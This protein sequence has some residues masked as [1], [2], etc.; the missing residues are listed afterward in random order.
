MSLSLV[1][2][3]EMEVNK[4]FSSRAQSFGTSH[5][6]L[7]RALLHDRNS[8][9]GNSE[10]WGGFFDAAKIRQSTKLA[11]AGIQLVP[12]SFGTTGSESNI[13]SLVQLQERSGHIFNAAN[14][15]HVGANQ[16]LE[17]IDC[18]SGRIVLKC[19]SLDQRESTEV[20]VDGKVFVCTGVVQT[21]DLLMRS[22][23]IK[24]GDVLTLDEFDYQLIIGR[25]GLSQIE[26]D[27]CVIS[28]TPGRAAAHLLGYQRANSL[29]LQ[30]PF[31]IHQVFHAHTQTLRLVVDGHALVGAPNPRID[32]KLD[33]FGK[34]IHYCNLRINGERL[35]DLAARLSPNLHFVSMASV[36][37][38]KPGPISSDIFAYLESIAH[39]L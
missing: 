28:Y 6:R 5:Y 31:E 16:S 25:A 20:T 33:T 8:I 29:S 30:K 19:A 7:T 36:T 3:P 35:A 21:M 2:R 22:E 26:R 24:S 17:S 34:S 14:H 15:L 12:L 38:S 23:Y 9:G 32:R 18:K 27:A 11:E 10:I 39:E 1:R 13:N 37:Q 4:L